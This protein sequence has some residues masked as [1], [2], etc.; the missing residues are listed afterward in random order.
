MAADSRQRM[1]RT[2]GRLLQRQGFHA[3]GLNQVVAESGAPKGSM[4]HPFPAGKEQ[5]AVEAIRS[6]GEFAGAAMASTLAA[7]PTAPEAVQAVVT[8]MAVALERSGFEYGC[9]I[10]TVA[11]EVSSDSAPVRAACD[12][13]FASWERL[14]AGRLVDDGLA[15]A[16]AAG[17]ATVVLAALEGGLILARTR[18]DPGPLMAVAESIHRLLG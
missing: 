9:P 10:A 7:G 16:T 12:E 15:P 3:T 13:V 11:L 2:M 4:Y 18:Q 8:G 17:T 1:I 6:A 14:I 5:L